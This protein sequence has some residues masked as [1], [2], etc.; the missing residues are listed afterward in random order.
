MQ[1]S[2]PI[3][4]CIYKEER[5]WFISKYGSCE[6]NESKTSLWLKVNSICINHLRYFVYGGDLSMRF[7]CCH[8]VLV[9]FQIFSKCKEWKSMPPSFL[10]FSPFWSITINLKVYSQYLKINLRAQQVPMLANVFVFSHNIKGGKLGEGE[11]FIGMIF[12]WFDRGDRITTF[13]FFWNPTILLHYCLNDKLGY[14]FP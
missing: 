2:P 11:V 1:P 10:S 13:W 12:F 9:P 5:W 8:I 6:C 7:L 14:Q 3:K 4:K